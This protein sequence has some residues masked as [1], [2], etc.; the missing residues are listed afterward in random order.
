MSGLLMR[1]AVIR[2]IEEH[3]EAVLGSGAFS[4]TNNAM[5]YRMAHDDLITVIRMM[6]DAPV[7][8]ILADEFRKSDNEKADMAL[9]EA[10]ARI[11][12]L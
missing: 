9:C 6:P 11:K 1:E 10:Y 12:E 7:L 4:K 8:D 3:A 5:I 2:K